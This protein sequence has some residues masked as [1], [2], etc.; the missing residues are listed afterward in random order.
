MCIKTL[1]VGCGKSTT[2]LGISKRLA[3]CWMLQLPSP[4]NQRKWGDHSDRRQD[5]RD[6]PKIQHRWRCIHIDFWKCC[7]PI[8]NHSSRNHRVTLSISHGKYLGQSWRQNF[9]T[10][11]LQGF[12]ISQA[13]DGALTLGLKNNRMTVTYPINGS[14][15]VKK[16]QI[17]NSLINKLI[18]NLCW[19]KSLVLCIC[20]VKIYFPQSN[21]NVALAIGSTG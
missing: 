1:I 6:K 15:F 17:V 10:C 8:S 11:S 12:E 5:T 20:K 4:K 7:I 2:S 21:W 9:Q 13:P 19:Y 3:V 14:K 18:E 16:K